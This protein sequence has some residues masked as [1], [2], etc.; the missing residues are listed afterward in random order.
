ME[1]PVSSLVKK[2]GE[3]IETNETQE[4]AD[5]ERK[6]ICEANKGFYMNNFFNSQYVLVKSGAEKIILAS[7]NLYTYYNL[8]HFKSNSLH[9]SEEAQ[10]TTCGIWL[11]DEYILSF[12]FANRLQFQPTNSVPADE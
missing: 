2:A 4:E 3:S 5:K 10:P 9:T 1:G 12:L 8:D 7:D 11:G 6:K